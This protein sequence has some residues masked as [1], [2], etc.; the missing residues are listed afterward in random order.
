MQKVFT[1]VPGPSLKFNIH[2]LCL[3]NRGVFLDSI[4][5][6]SS[7]RSKQQWVLAWLSDTLAFNLFKISCFESLS[8]YF[9]KYPADE[10]L[11]R[12]DRKDRHF[13]AISALSPH[14]FSLDN[15]PKMP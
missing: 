8:E 9:A 6:T 5:F 2:A 11:Q 10:K 14:N 15:G 12:K 1:Q 3:V 4:Q 7:L 13:W